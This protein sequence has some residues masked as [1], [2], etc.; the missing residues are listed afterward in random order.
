MNTTT[1]LDVFP[2]GTV[3]EAG[4]LRIGGSRVDDL[5]GAFGTPAYI[6]DEA[7]LRARVREMADGLTA[8]WP[9]SRT[10]FASKAFPSTAIY[11]VMAQEGLGIDVAGGGELVMA[12]AGGAAPERLLMHGNAKTD[13]ELKMALDAG[14]GV[15]VIDNLAE[16]D[17]IEAF[18]HAD[19]DVLVRLKPGIGA[20]THAAMDTGGAGSKFGM[21]EAT[22]REAIK[23]I[24]ATSHLRMRGVHVH[25]GSQIYEL[26]PFADAVAALGR[27]GTFEIY[28]LGGGLGERYTERDP[29][30]DVAAY[31]D[32]LTDAARAALPADAELFIEPGRSL[33]ARAGVTI[34]R[35]VSVKA[36]LGGRRIV[37]VDGGMGDNLD[38]SLYGQP[39]T[40]A[41]A[42]ADTDVVSCTIVGRHCESG[43]QLIEQIDLP[44]PEPGDLLVVP[45]TGA[46]CFTMSNNYNGALRPP[47]VFVRDGVPH[48]AVRRETYEDLL[49]RDQPA[50]NGTT[51]SKE[52]E[53]A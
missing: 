5:A 33:V 37:A 8:R 41:H 47:V 45:A 34:Y 39:F 50:P 20:P 43:D 31:L 4:V 26:G 42:T 35:V 27:L 21:D 40:A 3:R 17:R 32:T 16:I 28:D 7:A 22:A 14:V 18:A 15:I 29:Q 49:R 25:I 48:L 51:T 23:R 12:L 30:V 44:T 2:P 19:V 38:V 13:A 52:R 10:Y 11:R 36:G 46:Y 24:A 9:K 6:V 53:H 1:A